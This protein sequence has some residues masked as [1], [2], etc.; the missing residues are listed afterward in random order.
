LTEGGPTSTI[1]APGQTGG[2]KVVAATT[3]VSPVLT[4]A[5][6]ITGGTTTAIVITE[7]V[8]PRPQTTTNYA[9]NSI[10]ITPL[11]VTTPPTITGVLGG[12]TVQTVAPNNG[13]TGETRTI[14]AVVS[15][16]SI[17]L[18]AVSTPG[19][20]TTET[21]VSVVGGSI[22]TV[23]PLPETFVSTLSGGILTTVT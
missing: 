6:G 10:R 22:V 16:S 11:P 9:G 17:T 3:V 5:V 2:A 15:G 13:L 12:Q 7:K 1:P 19:Q 21:I 14:T 4:P 18:L 20:P 23:T 8:T